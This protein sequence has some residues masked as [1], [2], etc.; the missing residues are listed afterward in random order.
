MSRNS[1]SSP[2]RACGAATRYLFDGQLLGRLQVGYFECPVCRYVQTE[3]PYWLE[4]AYRRSITAS[5]TGIMVR[6]Q[7][8]ARLVL[9]TSYLL[10]VLN[11]TV[12]D[13]A[14]GYGILVRMLRDLGIN[15][16]WSDRY[17]ENLLASGFE[18]EGGPAQLVTAFEAFEH[19]VHPWQELAALL[20][21][22]PNV[23]ISTDIMPSPTPLHQDWWYYGPEHGQHI[24][25][26]RE[27]TLRQLAA[28]HGK[29]LLSDG[30]AYHLFT[31]QNLSLLQWR[32]V[33]KI[34]SKMPGL[35]ASRLSSK[36]WSDHL[37]MS[38]ESTSV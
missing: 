24:G 35:L 1:A 25:F 2:C 15:A 36:V 6:N 8:N 9:A 5:D 21:V 4:D 30:R 38:G 20:A 13:H 33:R 32:L 7:Y 17:S 27:E 11:G 31:D 26:F 37:Y 29:K 18:Y 14:G 34:I 19:F 16:L 3:E 10:G 12:V 28:K 23:L 22:A